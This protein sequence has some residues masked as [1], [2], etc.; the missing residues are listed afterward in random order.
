MLNH[1]NIFLV[2]LVASFG[3]LDQDT[4]NYETCNILTCF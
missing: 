2:E 3:Q 1:V 4:Q